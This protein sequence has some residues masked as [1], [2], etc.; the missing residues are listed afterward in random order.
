MRRAAREESALEGRAAPPVGAI[1]ERYGAS[2]PLRTLL[3]A[4][5]RAL[6]IAFPAAS[7]IVLRN[8][9]ADSHVRLLGGHNL[10][11]AWS[12]RLLPL[13]R[14]PVVRAAL[15]DPEHLLDRYVRLAP[16]PPQEGAEPPRAPL[17]HALCCAVLA[18]PASRFVLLLL[19]PPDP[20]QAAQ[21]IAAFNQSRLLMEAIRSTGSGA[22]IKTL[23]SIHRAK[24]EW[25]LSVDALPEIVGL[26]DRNL[27]VVRISRALERWRLGD[28]K[29]AIGA[30]L[31]VVLHPECAD[32]LCRLRAC[33][34]AAGD[35]VRN[36]LQARFE[37]SD[38][39]LMRDLIVVL[40]PPAA[41]GPETA[42]SAAQ[43]AV[44][45]LTDVTSQ[46]PA[47]RELKTLNQTLEERVAERTDRLSSANQSLTDE[48]ARRRAAE[49]SLR[50][51]ML[52]LE[53]LSEQLMNAQEDERKRIAQDLH[54][55]VGQTLSAIKYS[56][57]RAQELLRRQTPA[58]AQS[59]IGVVVERVRRLMEEVRAISM[60]L[61]P[62]M[63]DDLGAASAVR[64][65]CRDWQ[66][67][68]RDVKVQTEIAV[69][70]TDIPALLVTN[71][72][73]AVQESLN[74]VAR[75]AVARNVTVSMRLANGVLVVTVRDDGLGFEPGENLLATGGS[76]G[77]RGL[78]ERCEK[79]G[80]RFEISS[81]PG[82]GTLVQ[83]E[84]PIA[85]GQAARL[86]S[87]RLN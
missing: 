52:E 22:R 68:Y 30:D 85:T 24:L 12:H 82:A 5:A 76:R 63:L 8:D 4:A 28:V 71:V 10:P 62:A 19:A 1:A 17:M 2:L 14:L 39:V 72:F 79:T 66:E 46:R 3:S 47:G 20:R 13:S 69:Q 83:L 31:H 74:N 87:A 25:E 21:R 67:V 32:E 80:G 26:L 36:R 18:E 55:S 59:V 61:R 38:R 15:A 54:D 45:N 70:D 23:T 44:V 53:S 6:A 9:G 16:T 58:E 42:A 50:R 75:H 34:N 81:S 41:A 35:R 11:P 29:G 64:G 37:I 40:S 84:W 78:R 73:R 57:E 43:R 86:A 51:S 56:L 27:R 49:H 60:N 33:V 7:V 77:L 65:L 48:I